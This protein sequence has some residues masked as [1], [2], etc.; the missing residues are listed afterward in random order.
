MKKSYLLF[1]MLFCLAYTF[2]QTGICK[3]LVK[4]S[5]DAAPHG[6]SD[7]IFMQSKKQEE[8]LRLQTS[9]TG[10]LYKVGEVFYVV[11]CAHVI[12]R[13]IAAGVVAIFPDM[14][15]DSLALKEVGADTYLDIAILKFDKVPAHLA[16]RENYQFEEIEPAKDIEF[17]LKTGFTTTIPCNLAL[18]NASHLNTDCTI[19]AN[20]ALEAGM[21]GSPLLNEGK[22]KGIFHAVDTDKTRGFVLKGEVAKN[23]INAILACPPSDIRK[24]HIQRAFLGL[25]FTAENNAVYIDDVIAGTAAERATAKMPKAFYTSLAIRSINEIP[26]RN[27]ADIHAALEMQK[28]NTNVV[29]IF[30]TDKTLSITAK[31]LLDAD[32][33]KIANHYLSK[34][35]NLLIK[36]SDKEVTVFNTDLKQIRAVGYVQ[37]PY[38]D[39]FYI[40]YN[41]VKL[42]IM[43]RIC[44]EQKAPLMLFD[45]DK[46]P[47]S[48]TW[49]ADMLPTLY[50]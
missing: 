35:S 42:G 21:S 44:A 29:I 12:E 10:F 36:G 27:L 32:L 40:T 38:T 43:V 6:I 7:S 3:L 9:G 23:A 28:P 14:S 8:L 48:I 39:Y 26:I 22:V 49:K 50:Y 20:K 15:S 34:N 19:L 37:K 18:K 24:R 33:T 17:M 25:V 41:A 16:K 31:E 13:G 4:V 45:K 2:A 1:F 11:T 47:I 5:K 30:D 46:N